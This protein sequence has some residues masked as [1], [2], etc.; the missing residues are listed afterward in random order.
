MGGRGTSGARNSGGYI[1]RNEYGEILF[2]A[3]V[4]DKATGK[5]IVGYEF[6]STS[7]SSA[8]DDLI[9]NGYSVT[10]RTM[11]P[12]KLFDEVMD[13]TNGN[14]WDWEDAQV[15]FKKELKGGK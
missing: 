10:P 9:R 4:T 15:K 6:S 1:E 2:K 12:R 8:R 13:K 14:V 7:P 3:S 5:R 11:L